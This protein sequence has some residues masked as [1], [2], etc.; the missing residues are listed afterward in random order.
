MK[1]IKVILLLAGM[2]SFIEWIGLP[3]ALL[4][5]PANHKNQATITDGTGRPVTVH[6]PIQRVIVEYVDN[7]ELIRILQHEDKVV[8]VA[9][10][11]YIFQDCHRQFP[12]FRKTA[13]V[14]HPWGLDYEAV[15]GLRPDL[16]LTFTSHNQEKHMNLPGVNILF[17]GL[18]KPDLEHLGASNF[19]R[20][21]RNLGRLLEAEVRAEEYISWYKGVLESISKRTA[22]LRPDE[23]PKVLIS[24]YPR[25]NSSG[26]RYCAYA[27]NDTL[28]QAS[29]LAGGQ[30]LVE[31]LPKGNG[32]SLALDPEWVIREDPDFILLHCVDD[33]LASGYET[34][35]IKYLEQGV[36]QFSG[37]PELSGV[38]AVKKR[39]VVVL[40]GHFRNDA[41]GGALAAAYLAVLF[42]PQL[43]EDLDPEQIHQ[44]YLN[45]QRL[46]YDLDQ[47]GIFFFPPLRNKAGL[48]GIP[49]RYAGQGF[50][51]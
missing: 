40:D 28:S 16:L 17:L 29:R 10:Y 24:S 19:V 38:T 23:K 35:E 20:G 42:H 30:N 43:F 3:G 13:S 51:K 39:Q 36:A 47:H 9:G 31:S 26:S 5:G 15:L 2:I 6:L 7:A 50:F 37:A 12:K 45:M 25:C 18:Y 34:D 21:V 14:G 33:I 44:D 41:S 22:T 27:P 46:A 32:V 49:D 48:A 1:I 4:A 8:G 11:D